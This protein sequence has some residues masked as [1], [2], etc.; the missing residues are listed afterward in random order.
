MKK[1]ITFTL[2]ACAAMLAFGQKDTLK[3]YKID[4]TVADGVP[5]MDGDLSDWDQGY[6]AGGFENDNNLYYVTTSD[7]S[8]WTGITT[9]FQASVYLAHDGTYLYI[10]WETTLDDDNMSGTYTNS[11]CDRIRISFGAKDDRVY[12]LNH[13]LLQDSNPQ[14]RA[15]NYDTQVGI[16]VGSGATLP[17]YEIRF[18]IDEIRFYFPTTNPPFALLSIGTEDA[19][20]AGS[21][22]LGLGANYSGDKH[23]DVTNPWDNSANYPIVQFLD[24][25]APGVSVESAANGSAEGMLISACPNPFNPSTKIAVCFSNSGAGRVNSLSRIPGA[26]KVELVIYDMNGKNVFHQET[27]TSQLAAG[28]TWDGRDLRGTSVSSGV[29]VVSVSAGAKTLQKKIILNR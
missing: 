15:Y 12:V 8:G 24:E 16:S 3:V 5:V 23:D 1:I 26:Q 28:I 19:D 17:K 13:T 29:Y 25:Y 6:N 10:G 27:R 11:L 2:I 14:F 18:L 7:M 20:D 4:A 22:Y 9:D 21:N